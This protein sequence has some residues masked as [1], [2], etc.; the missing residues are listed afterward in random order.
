MVLRGRFTVRRSRAGGFFLQREVLTIEETNARGE[1]AKIRGIGNDPGDV[2][3]WLP[4]PWLGRVSGDLS[5]AVDCER[6]DREIVNRKGVLTILERFWYGG[7]EIG[8]DRRAL[9]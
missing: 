8:H 2:E 5:G 1:I 4:I 3:E 6:A 9:R 7:A